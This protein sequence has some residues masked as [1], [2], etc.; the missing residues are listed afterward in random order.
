[1]KLG[2][3]PKKVAL[4]TVL[5]GVAGYLLYKNAQPEPAPGQPAATA[6][7][8]QRAAATLAREIRDSVLARAPES[9]PSFATPV[10]G[11][12]RPSLKPPR[13]SERPDPFTTDPRL[14][15][16]LLERLRQ[17]EV[18][19]VRRNLFDFGA[20]PPPKLPEP[21][22]IP[23]PVKTSS[24]SQPKADDAPGAAP[25]PAKP[26]PSPISLKF[27]GYVATG[28]GERK[29]AFFLDGDEIFVASEGDVIRKR[30]KV[31]KIGMN[32]AVVQDLERNHEQTL[33]LEDQRS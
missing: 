9:E 25:S 17:V 24:P 26:P 5:M 11:Q 14:E 2:A 27:Y 32:F 18:A 13:A 21:K 20:A 22:I 29:R 1:M 33:P 6:P 30:Y 28:P 23:Q 31:V 3:E 15:L 8:Q 19:T 16:D 4:L 7:Q 10:T 12:F